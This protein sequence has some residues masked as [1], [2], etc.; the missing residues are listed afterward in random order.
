M[1]PSSLDYR[2]TTPRPKDTNLVPDTELTKISTFRELVQFAYSSLVISPSLIL[3]T[4]STPLDSLS[5]ETLL[6]LTPLSPPHESGFLSTGVK[7][8]R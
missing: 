2:P 4:L 1:C 7:S 6:L 3:C 5:S 8:S